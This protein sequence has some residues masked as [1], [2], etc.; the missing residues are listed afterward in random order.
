VTVDSGARRDI[1]EG[2]ALVQMLMEQRQ[3]LI[4]QLGAIEK[5]LIAL[6]RLKG[7]SIRPKRG[8]DE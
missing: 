7:R 5:L 4:I 8:S 2:E 1:I 3:A 6:G